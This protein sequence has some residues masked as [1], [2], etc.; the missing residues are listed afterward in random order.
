MELSPQAVSAATFKT[1]KRG[2][3]PDE[4]RSY[5]SHVAGSLEGSQQQSAA[6]E[7]RARAA[8]AKLQDLAKAAPAS[9]PTVSVGP[10]EAETISRTLLLAQRTADTTVAE[11]EAEAAAITKRAEEE[12]ARELEGAHTAAAKMVDEARLEARRTKDDEVTK[13]ENEVQALLARR[14]FLLSDVDHLEQH[15]AAQRDRLREASVALLDLVER[16]PGGLGDLRRPLLSASGEPAN[17]TTN[18]TTNDTSSDV[19]ADEPD[20]D[21]DAETDGLGADE[22]PETDDSDD[23]GDRADQL[24]FDGGFDPAPSSGASSR[25]LR[26][27]GDELH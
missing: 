12:V 16:V 2:Y 27:G 20:L 13:A 19:A 24:E 8:I 7:A 4:V 17:D 14:D 18:D 11:A 9:A 22:L 21:L 26:I 25:G 1:V 15:V 5:L 23:T 6:M 3:D 10:D